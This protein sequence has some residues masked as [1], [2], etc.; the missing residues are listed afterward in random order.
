MRKGDC[1][2]LTTGSAKCARGASTAENRVISHGNMNLIMGAAGCGVILGGLCVRR[3]ELSKVLLR[4]TSVL[5]GAKS[6]EASSLPVSINSSNDY[7]CGADHRRSTRGLLSSSFLSVSE[8]ADTSSY[9]STLLG[10][11]GVSSELDLDRGAALISVRCGVRL[12][13]CS[14]SGPCIFTRGVDQDTIGTI[15]RGARNIDNIRVRACLAQN[16]SS[17]SLT[18]RVLNT[19]N[20]LSRS[21]CGRLGGRKGDCSCSSGVN[22]FKVRL[23]YRSG[24][25]N[26]N[27]AEIVRQGTSKALIR[28]VRARD[29]GPNGAICLAVSSGLRGATMGSLRRGIG[30]TGRT[31]GRSKRGGGNRS[32]RANTIMV[33][34]IGSFSMLTTTDCPACSLG[35]CDR[36]NSCCIGLSRG[37]GSPVCGHTAIKA[38][39]YNSIFGPYITNT[40]LRRGVVASGAGVCYGRSCSFCPAGIMEYVRCRNDLSIAN[41]VRRSYGCFFTSANEELKVRPV[42]LCTRGFKLNRCANIRVRRS[43]KALTNESDAS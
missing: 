31:N 21:R 8:G 4:L 11:C 29:T 41:T 17:P 27:K 15:D 26:G 12:R 14:G 22:G 38:F 42:C 25:G 20:S 18:P 5:A 6:T 34:S 19:L 28:D 35:E 9:F 43:G 23:T 32:Y 39:T 1:G 3:S 36:C 40:T 13:G 33:L 2:D 10:H 30:T 7:I 16:T 37:G 24:L